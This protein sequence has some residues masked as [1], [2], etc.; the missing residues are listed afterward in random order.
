MKKPKW[1]DANSTSI[2]SGLACAGVVATVALAVRATP[3]AVNK[4]NLL[5]D[6]KAAE[7]GPLLEDQDAARN[8]DP[9][10]IEIVKVVWK[11]YLP[12]GISGVATVA[13]IVGANK[14]GLKRNA[15][16]LGAYTLVD[17]AFREYKDEVLKVIGTKKEDE[18]R[19]NISQKQV[20]ENPPVLKEIII[21]GGGDQMCYDTLTGRYF[22]SDIEKIR[23]AEN[24]I[25]AR[26]LNDLYATQNEFYR[27]IGLPDVA[28]G[29]ELGWCVDNRVDLI[30][31][32]H[33]SEPDG[34]P[35]IAIEYRSLPRAGYGNF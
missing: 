7:A 12:A 21:T 4:I 35:C 28:V 31:T 9:A 2:L 26:V 29:E 33:L 34:L 24:E 6:E 17:G 20:D 1:I 18:I 8:E 3:K 15:A 14:I 10:L 23:R 25:N 11:D 30:I 16:L 32:S 19:A 13:C 22:R 27:L 5:R